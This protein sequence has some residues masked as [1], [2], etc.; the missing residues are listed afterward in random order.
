MYEVIFIWFESKHTG[1]G[2]AQMDGLF[3]FIL[4]CMALLAIG[5][6]IFFYLFYN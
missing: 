3:T 1:I 4:I 5:V 6:V 2:N